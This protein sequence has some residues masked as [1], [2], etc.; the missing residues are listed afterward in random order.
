MALPSKLF[1][2]GLRGGLLVSGPRH[3]TRHIHWPSWRNHKCTRIRRGLTGPWRSC[4]WRYCGALRRHPGALHGPWRTWKHYW[5]GRDWREGRSLHVDWCWSSW[6]E[7]AWAPERA[8]TSTNWE[9]ASILTELKS[10]SLISESDLISVLS[11]SPCCF[12][13]GISEGLPEVPSGP[14]QPAFTCQAGII[15]I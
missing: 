10:W 1:T 7:T 5:R 2:L 4:L 8:D 6:R 15:S 12:R 3:I 14:C 13:P 9:L 11:S